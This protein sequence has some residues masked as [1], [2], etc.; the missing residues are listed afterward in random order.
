M[1]IEF[2]PR[3]SHELD[4]ALLRIAR[5]FPHLHTLTFIFP[6]TMT[7]DGIRRFAERCPSLREVVLPRSAEAFT[8][9]QR[10]ELARSMPRLKVTMV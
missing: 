1:V 5:A 6:K 3:P 9:K 10:R 4:E 8:S 2:V 7:P